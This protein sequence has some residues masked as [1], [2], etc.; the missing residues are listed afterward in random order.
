MSTKY[1]ASPVRSTRRYR[2]R[3]NPPTDAQQHRQSSE[4][5]EPM[6]YLH[7]GP[8]CRAHICMLSCEAPVRMLSAGPTAPRAQVFF[9]E[10]PVLAELLQ[11]FLG[12]KGVVGGGVQGR[13]SQGVLCIHVRSLL[14]QEHGY[15]LDAEECRPLE[16]RS[17]VRIPRSYIDVALVGSQSQPHLEDGSVYRQVWWGGSGRASPAPRGGGRQLHHVRRHREVFCFSCGRRG[18]AGLHPA[19]RGAAPSST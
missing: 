15:L 7:L 9:E 16:R 10:S 4:A 14:D 6:V 18:C 1:P 5:I 3:R 8:G 19:R 11:L 17:L 2:V 13:R 12:G